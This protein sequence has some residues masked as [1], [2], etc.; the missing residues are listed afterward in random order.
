MNGINLDILNKLISLM[1]KEEFVLRSSWFTCTPRFTTKMWIS[2]CCVTTLSVVYLFS[3]I[4]GARAEAPELPVHAAVE[5]DV[6]KQR[7]TLYKEISLLSSV[8]WYWLAALDQYER[9]I[10]PQSKMN[11]NSQRLTQISFRDHQWEGAFNPNPSDRNP[12]TIAMFGGLGIDANSDGKADPDSDRD[13]LFAV[14]TYLS[15]SGYNEDDIRIALWRYYQKDSAVRRI[16]QFAKI[17]RQYGVLNL[18]ESAFPLPLKSVYTYRDTWGARR[19][20]GGLRIHEGTDIFASHGVP[21]RSVCY[22]I[23]ETKGWNPYGGW[24]IGI[25]D[26]NNRY[27][28]YAHLQGYNKK[29]EVGKIVEPGQV[30]G[31]VGSSGYGPKGTQGKFAPHLHYGIYRDT[32]SQEWAFNPYPLLKQWEKQE[33]K[34][35]QQKKADSTK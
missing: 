24:R 27:H 34:S 28:Y 16:H 5:S 6:Y 29:I 25:R 11:K 12:A 19:G 35:I 21:V 30:I 3:G 15:K 8:P 22:G 17:Y 32:G 31:W 18:S 26:L 13:V 10:T 4:G 20:W 33:R 7:L 1:F 23:I 14:A 9:S 2:L